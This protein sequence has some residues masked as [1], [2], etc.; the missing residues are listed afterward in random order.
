MELGVP[1]GQL[2]LWLGRRLSV[3]QVGNNGVGSLFWLVVFL[4]WFWWSNPYVLGLDDNHHVWRNLEDDIVLVR[5]WSSQ[6]GHGGRAL[7]VE[8]GEG[9]GA[10]QCTV[11][12]CLNEHILFAKCKVVAL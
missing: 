5:E 11:L 8:L 2:S 1:E 10:L 7:L 6:D 12:L 9:E 3:R 4:L